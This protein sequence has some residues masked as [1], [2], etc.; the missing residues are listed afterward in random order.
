M[1]LCLC[2]GSIWLVY[3]IASV[4]MGA[5]FSFSSLDGKLRGVVVTVKF[6]AVAK[7]E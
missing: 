2:L 3:V 4:F 5:G 6:K 7:R 1:K